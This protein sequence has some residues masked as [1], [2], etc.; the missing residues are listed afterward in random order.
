M[1]IGMLIS[2]ILVNYSTVCTFLK[3][4][5]WLCVRACV[6]V[7]VC[8][9]VWVYDCKLSIY[10]IRGKISLC[11]ISWID[12]NFVS[13]TSVKLK[14][15]FYRFSLILVLYIL[16]KELVDLPKILTFLWGTLRGKLTFLRKVC[17]CEMKWGII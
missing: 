10:L 14:I 3:A 17:R 1:V 13:Y 5:W 7:C 8:V 16:L 15:P 6:C 12:I 2:F 11:C 4:S 9:C